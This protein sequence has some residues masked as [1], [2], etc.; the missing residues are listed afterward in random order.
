MHCVELFDT[1]QSFKGVKDL[2]VREQFINSC[3]KELAVHLREWAPATLDKMA[4]IADQYLDAHGR[5]LFGP[6][7]QSA[8]TDKSDEKKPLVEG[9]TQI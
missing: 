5:R 9:V 8:P 2:I 1:E 3:P 7:C 6:G 4:K